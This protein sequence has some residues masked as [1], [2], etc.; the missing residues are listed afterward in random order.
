MSDQ[1]DG[2][3]G[4]LR[5]AVA[6]SFA[7]IGF[8]T[9]VIFAFGMTSLALDQDVLSVPGLGYAP[10]VVAVLS[11]LAAFAVSLWGTI[12]RGQPSYA[13]TVIV[14]LASALAYVVGLWLT[15]LI[16]G[17]PLAIATAATG[18]FVTS[19]FFLVLVLAAAIAAWGGIALVRTR[20]SR[21]RWPWEDE[22]E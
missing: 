10:G 14:A 18:S 21:P 20:S 1:R 4:G 3:G 13:S 2:D 7:V 19:W 15:A 6:L 17:S 11:S 9:L 16:T 5:P 8:G 12:R 22:D